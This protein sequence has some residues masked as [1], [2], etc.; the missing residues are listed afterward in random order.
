MAFPPL[1]FIICF[2]MGWQGTSKIMGRTSYLESPSL[3]HFQW[4]CSVEKD[5]NI[6]CVSI[7]LR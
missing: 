4:S 1:F 7:N 6:L 3:I 2:N 5:P